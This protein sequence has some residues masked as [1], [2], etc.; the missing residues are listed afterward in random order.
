MRIS[1]YVMS[2]FYARAYPVIH[3]PLFWNLRPCQGLKKRWVF[4]R[5]PKP[6]LPLFRVFWHH[7]CPKNVKVHRDLPFRLND[8]LSLGFSRFLQCKTNVNF[9]LFILQSCLI[10]TEEKTKENNDKMWSPTH[11]QV[12]GKSRCLFCNKMHLTNIL[13]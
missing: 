7:S 4:L 3:C 10:H 2:N 5:S 6:F 1:K 13:T 11:V 9:Y 8:W 12:L